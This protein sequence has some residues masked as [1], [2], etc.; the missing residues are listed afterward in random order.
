MNVFAVLPGRIDEE[1]CHPFALKSCCL[2]RGNCLFGPRLL[3]E[4]TG[5]DCIHFDF[6]N[7]ITHTSLPQSTGEV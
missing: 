6:S 7:S 2:K 1:R 3:I 4:S 5:E